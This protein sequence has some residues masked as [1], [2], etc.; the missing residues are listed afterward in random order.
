MSTLTWQAGV[1]ALPD[2]ANLVSHLAPVAGPLTG[3]PLGVDKFFQKLANLKVPIVTCQ[4]LKY[5]STWHVIKQ[6]SRGLLKDS[7]V[8]T[9][10]RLLD[11]SLPKGFLWTKPKPVPMA[12]RAPGGN[13]N[14]KVTVT[15]EQQLADEGVEPLN[16]SAFQWADCVFEGVPRKGEADKIN[17]SVDT[18]F[19]NTWLAQ[20]SVRRSPSAPLLAPSH[21]LYALGF[22]VRRSHNSAHTCAR[23]R[24]KKPR[25]R[26]GRKSC[27]LL[28]GWWTRLASRSP[29]CRSTRS[30]AAIGVLRRSR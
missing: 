25:Q 17:L 13:G 26:S 7:S 14:N 8:V 27:R 22:A 24:L 21:H 15:L 23:S 10:A 3:E 16:A 20:N 2:E 28:W 19:D 11:P 1:E 30:T 4:A 6:H 29:S 12:K 9:I 5:E 18:L